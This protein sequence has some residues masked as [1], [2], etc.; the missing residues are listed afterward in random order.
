[1][2]RIHTN[3]SLKTFALTFQLWLRLRVIN[4]GLQCYDTTK[5]WNLHN[6]AVTLHVTDEM[7]LFGILRNKLNILLKVI[8]TFNWEWDKWVWQ[9]QTFQILYCF[10]FSTSSQA[11][12]QACISS[13]LFTL[14]E[15]SICSPTQV[16]VPL[17]MLR[18]IYLST[19]LN[20]IQ[21]SRCLRNFFFLG[22]PPLWF[23]D[24]LKLHPP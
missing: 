22:F 21:S 15:K 23:L 19:P 10:L 11:Y 7:R 8:K 9:R 14:Q 12:L 17:L 13:F 24:L 20:N 1:M 3:C 2:N 18:I 4:G 6:K 5:L 16:K